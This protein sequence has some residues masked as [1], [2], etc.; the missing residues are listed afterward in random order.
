M[1]HVKFIT[2]FTAKENHVRKTIE[3]ANQFYGLSGI[4]NAY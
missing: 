1:L 2:S 4:P 3:P